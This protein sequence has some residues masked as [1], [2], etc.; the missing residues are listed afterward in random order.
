MEEWQGS[1]MWPLSC[2][3][4]LHHVPYLPGLVDVSQEEMRFEAYKAGLSAEFLR[5]I[6][7]LC[8]QQA[9]LKAKYTSLTLEDIK[10]LVS[11]CMTD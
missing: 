8:R 5:N 10:Q 11:K 1:S 6:E 9:A 7:E 3:G 4:H 2:Y